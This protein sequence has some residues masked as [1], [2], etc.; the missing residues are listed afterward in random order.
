MSR[1]VTYIILFICK[2]ASGKIDGAAFAV[3]QAFTLVSHTEKEAQP[4][5]VHFME[6]TFEKVETMD[7]LD[8]VLEMMTEK[9]EDGA[10][11]V[12]YR[13]FLFCVQNKI[14]VHN[15]KSKELKKKCDE[16]E[17]EIQGLKGKLEELKKKCEGQ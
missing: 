3:T 5:A 7:Q 14:R 17:T 6:E 9:V 12:A 11:K 15:R 13:Y 2:M 1:N 16:Q 10:L 4:I 8:K